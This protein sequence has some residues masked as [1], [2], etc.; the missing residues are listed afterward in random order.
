MT[1]RPS[2]ATNTVAE[3]TRIERLIASPY[4]RLARVVLGIGAIAVGLTVVPQPAGIAV[5]AFGLVP[6]ASGAFN[7]CPIAPIWGGHFLGSRYCPSA[8]RIR[9]DHR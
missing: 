9:D 1:A 2:A 6:I 4:G 7:L 5:A 8:A 3:G